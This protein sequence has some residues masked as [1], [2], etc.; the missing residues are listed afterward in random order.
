MDTLIEFKYLSMMDKQVHVI[1]SSKVTN[2][3]DDQTNRV[4]VGH[5]IG[6]PKKNI[7]WSAE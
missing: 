2:F 6:H 7:L 1:K 3:F 4:L 5:L